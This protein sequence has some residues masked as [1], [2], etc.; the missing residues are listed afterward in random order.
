MPANKTCT[1]DVLRPAFGLLVVLMGI[2]LETWQTIGQSSWWMGVAAGCCSV[3][4]AF[5]SCGDAQ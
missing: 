5:L 2:A 4:T 1:I 3:H